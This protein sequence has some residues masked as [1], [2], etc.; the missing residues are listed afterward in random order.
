LRG[1]LPGVALFLGDGELLLEICGL[2]RGDG[3]LFLCG[4]QFDLA[5]LAGLHE[6]FGLRSVGERDFGDRRWCWIGGGGGR[7]VDTDGLREIH[8]VANER[9]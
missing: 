6:G 4:G 3:G 7:R 1:A 9:G 8:D 5:L 2:L